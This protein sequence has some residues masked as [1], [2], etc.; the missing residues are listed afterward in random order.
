MKLS[1]FIEEK[2]I[3]TGAFGTVKK[4]KSK[5]D[6]NYY[7]VKII[8]K[9]NKIEKNIVREKFILNTINHN[10]LIK[11][12]G[13]F[14]DNENQYFVTDYLPN[15]TLDDKIKKY[16]SNFNSIK[17]AVPIQENLVIIIFKQILEGLI[18]LHSNNIIH[19]DIKP[20][21][22]LFDENNNVK[23]TDFGISAFLKLEMYLTNPN[24][25]T[26]N[27]FCGTPG[28]IP[29]EILYGKEFDFKCD[30]YSLGMTIFKL[31]NFSLPSNNNSD[32]ITLNE[33]YSKELRNL[34]MRMISKNPDDRPIAQEAYNEL[35]QIENNNL[36]YLSIYNNNNNNLNNQDNNS[37]LISIL[38]CLF[39][40]DELNYMWLKN[41][42]LSQVQNQNLNFLKTFLPINLMGMKEVIDSKKIGMINKE[43]FYIFFYKLRYL[44]SLKSNKIKE[45]GEIDPITVFQELITFFTMD[46]KNAINRSIF[47]NNL[48]DVIN[49]TLSKEIPE[50][51]AIKISKT[52]KQNFEINYFGPFVNIFYFVNLNLIRCQFC[53]YIMN[54]QDNILFSLSIQTNNNQSLMN[55]IKNN[56]DSGLINNNICPQ[57]NTSNFRNQKLF[58]NSPLYLIIEFQN[59]N[60]II[61]DQTIDLSSYILSNVGPKIYNIFA[62]INVENINGQ[63]HYIATVKKNNTYMF[64]SDDICSQC[65]E[66]GLKCGVPCIAIYKGQRAC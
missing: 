19:R 58:V 37:S 49:L 51:I 24:L 4:M 65:G 14:E 3:G 50:S 59:K 12:Y 11:F 8:Q 2:I 10:N 55:L 26:N 1:D 42:I 32:K 7:A 17:E 28:Y 62:V 15:G 41:I 63:N 40:I 23:I 33:Y 56:I 46:F 18:Y 60:P 45:F 39:D 53:K 6:G 35:I 64:Y 54:Y 36:K 16:L 21:N 25:Y 66:E 57:C 48:F 9:Q 13:S 30:I 47:P 44:L 52:I 31:M 5:N 22:I 34:V 29:P 43:V 61:L 27:T 20:E 38:N